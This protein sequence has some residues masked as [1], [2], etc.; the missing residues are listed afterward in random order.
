MVYVL[1]DYVVEMVFFDLFVG[2][3]WVYYVGFFDLGFG[4]VG[5][6]G[7]GFCVV[8]EVCFYDVFFIVEYG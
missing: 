6:G 3:F 2:E 8:L 7:I 1:L 5:V 4:Y